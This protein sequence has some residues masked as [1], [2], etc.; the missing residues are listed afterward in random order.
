[1]KKVSKLVALVLVFV[2]AMSL[3]ACGGSKSAEKLY[4]TW[5][6][7]FDLTGEMLKQLGSDFA[8]FEGELKFTIYFDFNED[9]TCKLYADKDELSTD[10]NAWIDSVLEYAINKM[11]EQF[12]AQGIDKETADAAIE[13]QFGMPIDQYMGDLV[14]GSIDIDSMAAEMETT[15]VWEAK[16]DKLYMDEKEIQKNA[17]D[18]FKVEGDV[19]TIDAAEGADA[20][21]VFSGIEGM[22]YPFTFNRVK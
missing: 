3:I 16:G 7:E 1:M 21:D 6:S 19:L 5:S 12:E 18:I 10:M 11:Y 14:R 8:D 13:K 15:G 9:G 22:D 2:M 4:G 17:Y 20:S